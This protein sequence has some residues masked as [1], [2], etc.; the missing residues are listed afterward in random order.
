MN[1]T[2]PEKAAYFVLSLDEEQAAPLLSRLKDDDLQRLHATAQGLRRKRLEP[3]TLRAIYSEFSRSV[4]GELPILHGGGEYLAQ[5]LKK[6]LGDERAHLL[7]R[8]PPP[9]SGPLDDVATD[10]QVLAEM[11]SSEHPQTVA[12][13]LSQVDTAIA[14]TVINAMPEEMQEQVIDRM[15]SL[16]SIS[17]V[18]IRATRDTLSTELGESMTQIEATSGASRVAAILNSMMPEQSAM[19]LAKIEARSPE[20]AA[21]IRREQFT[22]EDLAKL[23][24]RGMQILLRE[25]D[26]S[27]LVMSLKTASED[28]RQRVFSSMSSRAAETIKEDLANLGPQRLMDVEK[29]QRDIVETA[30]RLQTEGKLV[31]VTGGQVV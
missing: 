19:L 11:L 8:G 5:L 27:Q 21:L 6:A 25:I 2:G 18:A 17:P 13:V 1:L 29:A 7:L 26:A 23:D 10:G 3:D 31:L 15:A 4:S 22:F 20:R 24:R 28:V 16:A 14:S 30:I 9:V 12:A